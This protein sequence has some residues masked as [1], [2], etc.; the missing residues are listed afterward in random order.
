CLLGILFV[1]AL[2]LSKWPS[3]SIEPLTEPPA[4]KS[5]AAEPS[6]PAI[7]PSPLNCISRDQSNNDSGRFYIKKD[8][9]LTGLQQA[10]D[11]ITTEL[12]TI[13]K[14]FLKDINEPDLL[15][16]S[17]QFALDLN[18]REFT[19]TRQ[20]YI[21][22]VLLTI[23]RNVGGAH[24][25]LEY[26]TW[27][28]DRATDRLIDLEL[29]FQAEHNPLPTIYSLVKEQLLQSEYADERLIDLGTGDKQIDHYRNFIVSGDDLVFYFEPGTV[30]ASATGPQEVHLSLTD[31]QA[32]LRPPFLNLSAVYG[33]SEPPRTLDYETTASSCSDSDGTWLNDYY[34]CEYISRDWCEQWSGRFNDCASACSHDP[35]AELCTLQCVPVCRL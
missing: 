6:L 26:R 33:D 8:I 7:I 20:P 1:L 12:Q 29:L 13:E 18:T 15:A 10:D 2:L 17:R 14:T 21:Q 23:Y 34:E 3:K 5:S 31:L 28:Y 35:T 24:P 32:L 19:F 9:C 30:A 22:S 4:Q 16:L 11:S 27:T 25:N